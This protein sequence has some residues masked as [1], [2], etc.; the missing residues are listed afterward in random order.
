MI[1]HTIAK[2]FTRTALWK[3]LGIA[4]AFRFAESYV[5]GSRRVKK[6]GREG[7]RNEVMTQDKNLW[8]ILRDRKNALDGT[9]EIKEYMHLCRSIARFYK[10]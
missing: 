6:V 3:V 4:P 7:D 1:N 10:H 5:E 8:Q 9:A 2:V